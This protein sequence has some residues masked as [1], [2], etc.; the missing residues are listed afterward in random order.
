MKT[1][2]KNCMVANLD[3]FIDF[4]AT[5]DI[6]IEKND[7]NTLFS[8]FTDDEDNGW[9]KDKEKKLNQWKLKCKAY[10]WA[11]S[12]ESESYESNSKWLNRPTIVLTAVVSV[13]STIGAISESKNVYLIISATVN[14]LAAILASIMESSQP[15]KKSAVHADIAGKYE[16]ISMS[17]EE[18]LTQS[19]KDRVNGTEYLK[20]IN[21]KM[22]GQTTGANRISRK[23]WNE[24]KTGLKNG[25]IVTGTI[26]FDLDIK[27]DSTSIHVASEEEIKH[28]PKSKG[29]ELRLNKRMDFDLN[30]NC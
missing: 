15:S 1:N 24:M 13:L 19:I 11:H 4:L 21:D 9:T 6:S 30:Q 25:Q 14:G 2:K 10:G 3:K 27:P 28:A 26:E 20:L 29:F 16:K 8:Y 12:R 18:Q 17:I 5:K 22:Q 7:I 23:V